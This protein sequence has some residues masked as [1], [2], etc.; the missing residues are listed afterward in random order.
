MEEGMKFLIRLD[1]RNFRLFA[2]DSTTINLSCSR[3]FGR[4]HMIARENLDCLRI[5]NILFERFQI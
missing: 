3:V 1:I 5:A 4:D 2:F